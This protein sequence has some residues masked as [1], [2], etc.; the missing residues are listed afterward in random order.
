MDAL[1][2]A[3]CAYRVFHQIAKEDELIY[4]FFDM[5]KAEVGTPKYVANQMK[6]KGLQKLRW[7]C[8]ICEKQCRDENGFKCHTQSESHV[9]NMLR[10]GENTK[11]SIDQYSQQFKRDFIT[12]LRSGHGE[13][14]I[15]ANRF[16]QEYIRDKNHIHMNATRW[17]TLSEF[18]KYLGREG[19]C[20][21]EETEKDG[22]CIA[23][24]DNSPEALKRQEA[25]RQKEKSAKG[26]EEVS[27]LI[28]QKQVEEA[29]KLKSSERPEKTENNELKRSDAHPLQISLGT[30]KKPTKEASVTKPKPPSNA[31]SVMKP[32]SSSNKVSKSRDDS[33]KPKSALERIMMKEQRVKQNVTHR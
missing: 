13:K 19:I 12:L 3:Q 16:Y 2:N 27:Q 20:R 28:L 4:R 32:K 18:V 17:T 26:D 30:V 9:R 8:Q 5:P 1:V 33:A 21:V 7:Y 10:V 23:Y 11:K 24:I 25:L 6:A 14:K 22:L 31:L 29:Q 15:N